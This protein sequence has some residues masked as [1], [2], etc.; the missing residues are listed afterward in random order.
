MEDV[1]EHPVDAENAEDPGW[2]VG[3]LVVSALAGLYLVVRLVQ[4]V[5]RL[6]EWLS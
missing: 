1:P 2:P 6:F 3:F 4:L 5:V